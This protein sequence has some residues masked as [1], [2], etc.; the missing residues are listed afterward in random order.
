[1]K[2]KNKRGYNLG[3]LVDLYIRKALNAGKVGLGTF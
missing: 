3:I 2:E 1:M